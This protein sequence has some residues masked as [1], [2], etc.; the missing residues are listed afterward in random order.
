MRVERNG[1]WKSIGLG[2]CRLLSL[3]SLGLVLTTG[4]QSPT[5]ASEPKAPAR[6]PCAYIDWFETGRGDGLAGLPASKLGTYQE[7]CNQTPYPV[8]T[9]QY[10]TGRETGLVDFCSPT[11]GLEAGRRLQA[12]EKV[13]PENLEAAFLSQYELGRKIHDL[14][15]DRSELEDR[16]AN[17][18]QLMPASMSPE[19]QAGS[20]IRAQID[21]LK[22]RQ[23]KINQD[24]NSL[25]NKAS[26]TE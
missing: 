18:R 16:I 21:Q 1:Q 23:A 5:I 19:A 7:R 12:Y 17:L 15:S 22:A 2:L 4:C 14:E 10:L 8:K 3:G 6:S 13:C 20:S 26:R 25:E 11:G 24:L 9:D